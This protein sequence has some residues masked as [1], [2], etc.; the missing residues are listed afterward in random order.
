M[1]CTVVY[2][3]NG[4]DLFEGTFEECVKYI[5]EVQ[6]NDYGYE[7]NEFGIYTEDDELLPF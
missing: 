2:E 3:E 1:K 5:D 7:R 4:M 6:V